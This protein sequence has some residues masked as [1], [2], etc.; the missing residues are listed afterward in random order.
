MLQWMVLHLYIYLAVPT[1]L[2]DFKNRVHD[3]GRE[4]WRKVLGRSSRRRSRE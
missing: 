2:S 1:G 3:A 4:I